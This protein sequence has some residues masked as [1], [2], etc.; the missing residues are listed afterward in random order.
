MRRIAI[1]IVLAIAVS[2]LLPSSI[3]FAQ[4]AASDQQSASR[5]DVSQWDRQYLAMAPGI[6]FLFGLS[7]TT[8]RAQ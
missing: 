7:S 2:I 6:T 5:Q 3:C 8:Y 1:S 4:Q